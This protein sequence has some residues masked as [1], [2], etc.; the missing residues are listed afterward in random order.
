M[1]LPCPAAAVRSIPT[2]S[3]TERTWADYRTLFEANAT[4]IVQPELLAALA[5]AMEVSN[6]NLP[7]GH[8]SR[9]NREY[10]VEAGPFLK[11]ADEVANLLVGLHQ[12][13]PVFSLPGNPVS[14]MITFEEFVR[15][16]LLKMMGHSGTV[17]SALLARD[18][19]A[20]L[21]RLK[22]QLASRGKE[23]CAGTPSGD[24]DAEK[25]VGLALRAYPLIEMLSAAAEQ[26]AD[27]M[28]QAG[29]PPL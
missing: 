29:E 1:R 25:P 5:Q 12:G 10:L 4:T 3:R 17:P 6:V 16:A 8:F 27:V 19:P 2:T 14:T 26:D 28:W 24:D 23:E 20:A 7:A 13:K 22:Q 18:I 21:A 11:S 9:Q 15:P